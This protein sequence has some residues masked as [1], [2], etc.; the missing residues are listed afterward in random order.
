MKLTETQQEEIS[1]A[2]AEY[3]QTDWRDY[4]ND[5]TLKEIIFIASNESIEKALNTL[6][7][8]SSSAKNTWLSY[9]K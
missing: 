3:N 4:A 8:A 1:N 2:L 9:Q 7:R 5:W 6:L